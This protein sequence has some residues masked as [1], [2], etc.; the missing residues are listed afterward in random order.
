MINHINCGST[1][2]ITLQYAHFNGGLQNEAWTDDYSP[3]FYVDVN[4]A[5]A[6]STL[7]VW[8]SYA[9]KTS[10]LWAVFRHEL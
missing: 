1:E 6:L 9:S 7:L 5:I 3:P 8:L 10:P 2:V 4:T